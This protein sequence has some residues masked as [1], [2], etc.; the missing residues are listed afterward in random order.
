MQGVN[1]VKVGNGAGLV[2]IAGFIDDGAFDV[3]SGFTGLS[4][5]GLQ[6][7]VCSDFQHSKVSQFYAVLFDERILDGI[8]Y[9]LHDPLGFLLGDVEFFRNSTGNFAFGHCTIVPIE[10]LLVC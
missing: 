5:S 4:M 1:V 2:T 3:T 9:I 8:Q 10:Q 6:S 7:V